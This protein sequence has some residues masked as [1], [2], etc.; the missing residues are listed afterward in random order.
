[1]TPN[2]LNATSAI[3]HRRRAAE[4]R[5]RELARIEERDDDDRAEIVEDR[6]RRQE[7]LEGGRHARAEER[8]HAEREGDVGRGR[9]RPAAQQLPGRS[10]LTAR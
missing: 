5:Q 1:M 9:D 7:D 2:R 8:E 10:R 6:E 4:H 3:R